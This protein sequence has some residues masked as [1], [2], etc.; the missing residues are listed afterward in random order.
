M[1][2]CHM[3]NGEIK[4]LKYLMRGT[5]SASREKFFHLCIESSIKED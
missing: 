1:C 3:N 4:D 2:K 5:E